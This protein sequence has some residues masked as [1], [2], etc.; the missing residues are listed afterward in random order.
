MILLT[1]IDIF[2]AESVKRYF[3]SLN[4]AMKKFGRFVHIPSITKYLN[5]VMLGCPV[6]D[7]LLSRIW[8]I[9]QL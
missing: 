7:F 3:S 5:L 4:H 8:A 9:S 6:G 2:H 1:V